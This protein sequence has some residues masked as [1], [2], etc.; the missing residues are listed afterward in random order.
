MRFFKT[1]H[2]FAHPWQDVTTAHWFKYPNENLPHVISVDVLD[3]YVD[4]VTNSLVTE[5]LITCRQN[6][7]AVIQLVLGKD[8]VTQYVREVSVIDLEGRRC[9][10]WSRNLSWRQVVTVEERISYEQHPSNDNKTIFNQE[11]EIN[12]NSALSRLKGYLEDICVST[13]SDNAAKGREAFENI[14][15]RFTGEWSKL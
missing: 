14:L 5:R 9:T 8:I 15:E 1:S 4:P 3:R 6:A 10:M 7:P 2:T 12:A 13:F 11:A